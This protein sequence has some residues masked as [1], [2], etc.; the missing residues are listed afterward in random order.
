MIIS[1]KVTFEV[2]QKWS[3]IYQFKGSKLMNRGVKLFSPVKG[4]AMISFGASFR[5]LHDGGSDVV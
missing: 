1:N 2:G 3:N 4:G 5:F